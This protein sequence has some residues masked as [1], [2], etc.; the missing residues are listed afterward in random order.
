MAGGARDYRRLACVK[1]AVALVCVAAAGFLAANVLAVPARVAPGTITLSTPVT[2]T[3]VTVPSVPTVTLPIGSTSVPTATTQ[4]PPTVSAPVTTTTPTV[5]TTTS[6]VPVTTAAPA[7]PTTTAPPETGGGSSVPTSTSPS[8]PPAPGTSTASDSG[9]PDASQTAAQPATT[10]AGGDP[11]ARPRADGGTFPAVGSLHRSAVHVA[12]T[13]L[14]LASLPTHAHRAGVR[15]TFVLAAPGRVGFVVLGPLPRCDL[16][17]RL[18]YRGRRGLNKVPFRGRIDGRLLRAGIYVIVP[19]EHAQASMLHGRRLAVAVDP[20][21]A[22]KVGHAPRQTCEAAQAV[23]GAAVQAQT[24]PRG[25]VAGAIARIAGPSPRLPRTAGPLSAGG[26]APLT[27]PETSWLL[28]AV[29]VALGGSLLLIAVG[30]VEL[31]TAAGRF[32]LVRTLDAHR[33]LAVSVGVAFLSLAAFLFLVERL[34]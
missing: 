4:P 30:A 34:P 16:A 31:P 29:L 14:Q 1:L 15:L 32:R 25:G 26:G 8:Q 33:Q 19:E 21:G 6:V 13:R 22:H 23:S 10:L 7:A 11:T 2:S 17:G 28:A 18:A 24:R 27:S 12:P 9:L 5:G 3:E 20:R